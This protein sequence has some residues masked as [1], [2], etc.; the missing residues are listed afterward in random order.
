MT[1]PLDRP[2]WNALTTR[3]VVFADGN[4]LAWRFRP[5]LIPFAAARDDSPEA[6]AA[7]GALP[8]P[9]EHMTLAELHEPIVPPGFAPFIAAPIVQMLAAE[10]PPPVW[11]TRIE[12]LTEADAAEM[13]ELATET[14]PGPFTLKAQALGEFHG[15][16]IDGRIAAMAGERMKQEGYAELS[17]VCVHPD[18]RGQGLARLLS[19]FVTHRILARGETPY[20]HAWASNAPAI[21]LYEAIGYATRVRLNVRVVRRGT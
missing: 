8:G 2:A 21:A 18:F 11:D 13:L 7:L 19:I 12:R 9:G 3:Q 14:R 17:G 16:R 4:E 10:I 5:E 1:H 20:L 15:V 6:V